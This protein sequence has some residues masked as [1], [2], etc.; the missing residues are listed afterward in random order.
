MGG[1]VCRVLELHPGMLLPIAGKLTN[2][3]DAL[4]YIGVVK[5]AHPHW[6]LWIESRRQDA[7]PIV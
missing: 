3:S 1:W 4:V 6:R 2:W 7:T 5:Q